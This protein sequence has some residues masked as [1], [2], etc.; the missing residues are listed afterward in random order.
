MSST[1]EAKRRGDGM[2]PVTEVS[3]SMGFLNP[4]G[5]L[6]S[7]FPGGS[8]IAGGLAGLLGGV[9]DKGN[10]LGNTGYG[11]NRMEDPRNTEGWGQM[12]VNRN[13]ML[14]Q[15]PESQRK[16][17]EGRIN[18]AQG[19]ATQAALNASSGLAANMGVGG[20]SGIPMGAALMNN[21]AALNAAAPYSQ[22][23]VQNDQQAMAARQQQD[24]QL[25]GQSNDY[26]NHAAHINLIAANN[27]V[28]NTDISSRIRRGLL[29]LNEGATIFG[30][31]KDSM[32]K[33]YNLQTE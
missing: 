15:N 29:G 21:S 7:L 16:M 24:Q 18:A 1:I 26:G 30:N 10:A 32:N 4:I 33:K 5:L 31:L 13:R 12:N 20:D 27:G 6:E 22:A 23:M 17:T 25:Q 2:E 14:N 28:S 9:L 3:S 19:A 8:L 11:V